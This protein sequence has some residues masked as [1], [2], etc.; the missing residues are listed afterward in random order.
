MHMPIFSAVAVRNER[1]GAHAGCHPDIVQ[2]VGTGKWR[3]RE[4]TGENINATAGA[5]T[6]GGLVV[7]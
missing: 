3:R 1:E 5:P 6:P 2:C 7:A 4:S